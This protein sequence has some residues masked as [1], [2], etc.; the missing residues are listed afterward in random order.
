[1]T[2]I[3][4]IHRRLEKI[5]DNNHHI[6][7]IGGTSNSSKQYIRLNF[8]GIL[9]YSTL[10]QLATHE[11]TINRIEPKANNGT[12]YLYMELEID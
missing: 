12:L 2:L 3:A 11:F 9:T 1:M 5:L 4:E 7:S 8:S 10:Y 6:I